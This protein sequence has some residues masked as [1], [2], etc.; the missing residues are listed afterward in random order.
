MF[1]NICMS[2]MRL[3]ECSVRNM[4]VD[5]ITNIKV[6]ELRKRGIDVSTFR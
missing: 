1:K 5:I 2:V 3:V 6:S 4:L